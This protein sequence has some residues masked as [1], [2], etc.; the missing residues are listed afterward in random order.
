MLLEKYLQ[1][2]KIDRQEFAQM[3]G[4]T[5]ECVGQWIRGQRFPSGNLLQSIYIITGGKVTP[6]DIFVKF[7]FRLRSKIDPT[8]EE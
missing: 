7:S 2:K 4:V 6:N 3:M 8:D 1:K 5:R